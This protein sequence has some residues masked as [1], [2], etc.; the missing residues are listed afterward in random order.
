M[1]HTISTSFPIQFEKINNATDS[2]FTPVRIW[3]CHTQKNLNGSYFDKKVLENMIPSLANVP[4]VGYITAD[5]VNNLD[6]NGHEQRLVVERDNIKIEYL[7][8]A[9][10]LIPSEN[11]ATFE[12]KKCD[13]GVEREFL[14]CDGIL[15]NKFPEC[16][17]IFERDDQKSQSMELQSDS[18]VGHFGKDNVFY[19]DS[20]AVEAACILGSGILPAMSGSLV[21]KY[22]YSSIKEQ[23]RELI[24]EYNQFQSQ[25]GDQV[26]PEDNQV[27]EPVVEP[28]EP[29]V[30]PTP[31]QFSL[32]N[33]QLRDEIRT[34]LRQ[35]K[36]KDEWGYECSKYCYLDSD[37]EKV[38][39]YDWVDNGRL[40]AFAYAMNGDSIAIDFNTRQRM[41]VQ[42]VP[43]EEGEQSNFELLPVEVA[44]YQAQLKVNAAEAKFTEE[45]D[46]LNAQ[47]NEAKT[48]YST[49]EQ[50]TITLREYAQQ[51]QTEEL[52]QQKE[53]LFTKLSSQAQFTEDEIA[54]IKAKSDTMSVEELENSF[55]IL[56]GKKALA[57]KFTVVKEPKAL[58]IPVND[59]QQVEDK[60][61]GGK[62][63]KYRNQ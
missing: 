12:K 30:E 8:R 11:N 45:K 32:T 50:E 39:A 48:A 33:E 23:L 57:G 62:F 59:N 29:I 25:G 4:I 38:Y 5:S 60:P 44:E 2:R 52:N 14:V 7:G 41:K 31:A 20:C 18:I 63:E 6:F 55:V 47:I 10:G 24:A 28:T 58:R 46:T 34:A 35:E 43:M 15:W 51:K 27:L 56:A 61:Y 54:E 53:Q 36:W 16:I 1:N 22:S 49:L 17:D 9:Y 40:V 42:Y 37:S 26:P 19:F 21:E 3:L 13:D